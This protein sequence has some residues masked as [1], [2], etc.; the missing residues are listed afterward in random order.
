MTRARATVATNVVN[1][2]AVRKAREPRPARL[3]ECSFVV[4]RKEGRKRKCG[5]NHWNVT[6]TGRYSEDCETGKKLA[7]E[8]L[9]FRRQRAGGF[10][11]N[12]IVADMPR[13]REEGFGGVEIGF[14]AT[15]GDYASLGR[16]VMAEI[17]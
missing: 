5:W 11:L 2:A 14:L 7:V 10:L 1:L 8:Y 9:E 15:V 4:A 13:T 6:C 12:W 16:C 17:G 3:D